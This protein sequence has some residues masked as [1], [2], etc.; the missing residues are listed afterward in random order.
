MT[1]ALRRSLS[2]PV[3]FLSG[4]GRRLGLVAEQAN[5]FVYKIPGSGPSAPFSDEI[6]ALDG[7][8]EALNLTFLG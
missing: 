2:S 6:S 3:M 5:G 4:D 8:Y 7:L 1:L